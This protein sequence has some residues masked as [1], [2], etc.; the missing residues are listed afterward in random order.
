[1]VIGLW[2]SDEGTQIHGGLAMG[3]VELFHLIGT[4]LVSDCVWVCALV[5]SMKME[6]NYSF[7]LSLFPY[8]VCLLAMSVNLLLCACS[9]VFKC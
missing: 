2:Q 1:M 6:C 4:G 3:G 8:H 5:P 7:D 9:T